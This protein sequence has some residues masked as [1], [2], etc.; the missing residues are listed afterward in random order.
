MKTCREN[1]ELP[2]RL[3]REVDR[4]RLTYSILTR[5]INVD[6]LESL[7]VVSSFFPMHN[8]RILDGLMSTWVQG[9]WFP[10]PFSLAKFNQPLMRIR[11][12]FGEKISTYFAWLEF[13]TK[14][15]FWPSLFGIFLWFYQAGDAVSVFSQLN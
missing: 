8:K 1:P 3:F 9:R 2:P 5:H 12:Y 10:N 13:Y 15:L 4:I 7:R 6:A 14:L 11:N